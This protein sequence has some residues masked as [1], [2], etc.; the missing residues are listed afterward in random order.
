MAWIYH[1]TAHFQNKILA[2]MMQKKYQG[3]TFVFGDISNCLGGGEVCRFY[4][5][6]IE[7]NE[8]IWL[9]I[10][11]SGVTDSGISNEKEAKRADEFSNVMYG[12]LKNETAFDYAIIGVEVGE[13]TDHQHLKEDLKEPIK[14]FDFNGLVISDNLL[15]EFFPLEYDYSVLVRF[16]NSPFKSFSSTH[17]WIP[18]KSELDNLTD[19][20][21]YLKIES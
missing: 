12:M 10:V 3:Q 8:N 18:K 2:Q 14:C 7:D 1:F 11:P 16:F 19:R 15:H 17:K 5:W 9:H 6:I 21:S 13:F 4:P 20:Q